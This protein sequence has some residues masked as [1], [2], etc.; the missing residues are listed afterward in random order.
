MKSDAELVATV[1]HGDRKTYATLFRRHERS[2]LAVALGVVPDY[3]LAQDVVQETFT[4]AFE[5]LATLRRPQSFGAW[6]RKIA[7]RAA[8]DVAR[9]RRT[10]AARESLDTQA[11]PPHNGNPDQ[12]QRRLLAAVLCLPRHEQLALT[13]HYF[14]GHPVKT[15][16]RMTGR[17]VGTVTM[18]L[19]RARARLRRMLK[20]IDDE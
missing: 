13:L 1:L 16:S 15:I 19:S 17:P 5:K 7:R 11:A 8:L 6:V 10:M 12:D 20:E 2:V 3:H 9:D 4:T 14:E 18:R